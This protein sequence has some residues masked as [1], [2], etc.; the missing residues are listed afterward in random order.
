[1]NFTLKSTGAPF[2]LYEDGN[3]GCLNLSYR[4][5]PALADWMR[6]RLGE[7]KAG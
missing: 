3:H 6:D 4:V 7:V 2:V 1:M 5:R